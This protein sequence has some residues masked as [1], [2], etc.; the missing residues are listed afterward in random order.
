MKQINLGDYEDDEIT[1][2][3]ERLSGPGQLAGKIC[4][5][6]VR[7]RSCRAVK[8]EDR[9]TGRRADGAVVD[10]PEQEARIREARGTA[11]Q[12]LSLGGR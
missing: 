4:G 7:A 11:A 9:F 2:R 5:E 6:Q 3:I 12:I 1:I 10:R 8:N